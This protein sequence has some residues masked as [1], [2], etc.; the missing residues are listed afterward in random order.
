[1]SEPVQNLS[2]SAFLKMT[3][4]SDGRHQFLLGLS[5][6]AFQ[7]ATCD[8]Q[9]SFVL[10]PVRRFPEAFVVDRHHLAADRFPLTATGFVRAVVVQVNAALLKGDAF[11]Q[12][13][14]SSVRLRPL[15]V[16]GDR[17]FA[18]TSFQCQRD[19]GRVRVPGRAFTAFGR[20]PVRVFQP[21]VQRAHPFVGKAVS[22][23]S[24]IASR[25]R[26]RFLNFTAFDDV[27]AASPFLLKLQFFGLSKH[28]HSEGFDPHDE[29]VEFERNRLQFRR[30]FRD[31]LTATNGSNSE[32]NQQQENSRSSHDPAS[33][34]RRVRQSRRHRAVISARRHDDRTLT[35]C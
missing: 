16:A 7:D 21:T 30:E 1:M 24:R 15:T 22:K 18:A 25:Q 2:C 12:M 9:E 14:Q 3:E 17:L 34:F 23:S 19:P 4:Q 13:L 31:I 28:S 6:I 10:D 26:A 5:V 35:V 29:F 32:R 8:R 20:Q 11:Q 33:E 27:P